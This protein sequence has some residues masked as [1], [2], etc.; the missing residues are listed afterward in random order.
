MAE[1][2][3]GYYKILGRDSVDI[4]NP[5]V[6]ISALEIEDVLLRPP[7]IKECAVVGIADQKWGEVVAVALCSSENLTLKKYKLGL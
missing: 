3:D 2:V 5:E 1:L 4:I 6:K 7:M